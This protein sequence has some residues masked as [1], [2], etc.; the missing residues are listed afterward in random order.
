LIKTLVA[1][2]WRLADPGPPVP[3]LVK[4]APDLTDSALEEAVQVCTAAGAEGL[5][6]T[7]TTL[8]RDGFSPTDQARAAEPGGLSGAPLTVRARQVVRFLTERTSL[9]VIAV[10]GIMTR[11]DGQAMLDAGAALLQVYTGYIYAGPALVADLN[12]LVPT[13][14][15]E[16]I[17]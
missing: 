11:D 4:L 7:N 15:K 9:P 3:I 13:T 1:E 8:G 6:A 14:I 16:S 10:G 5:I 2:A 12:R 17:R